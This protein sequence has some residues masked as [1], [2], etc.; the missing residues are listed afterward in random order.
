MEV[1]EAN[2]GTVICVPKNGLTTTIYKI[3]EKGYSAKELSPEDIKALGT[4]A[5]HDLDAKYALVRLFHPV[6]IPAEEIM[7]G[8][9]KRVLL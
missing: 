8:I 1:Q 7:Q 6:Q 5:I 4:I 2:R 9:L 3:A